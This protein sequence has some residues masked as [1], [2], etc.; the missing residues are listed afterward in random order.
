MEGDKQK[1]H[2]R[3]RRQWRIAAWSAAA[4]VLLLPLIA[5]QLTDEVNWTPF[6]FLF[7]GALLVSVGVAFEL[8]VRKTRNNAYR[9]GVGIAL[10]AA[11]LLIWLNGAV[12]IIGSE[13]N[14]LNMMYVGVLAVAIVGALVARFQ[15]EGMAR[16][17]FATALAQA[18]V[19]A[20]ALAAGFGSSWWDLA[21]TV[22]LNGF[23]ATLWAG[24]A[25]LFQ[26]AANGQAPRDGA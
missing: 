5:M 2:G 26:M 24:S 7:A 9:A 10:A 18:V 19:T 12:G 1:G 25:L 22:L 3:R 23:F 15:G 11:F 4:L 20:I 13:D 21:R 17:M 16:A 6:D 8:T 14:P